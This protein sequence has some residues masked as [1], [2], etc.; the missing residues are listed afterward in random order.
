MK[1]KVLLILAFIISGSGLAQ[2]NSSA[3]SAV[4]V[5]VVKPLSMVKTADLSFGDIASGALDGTVVIA[6]D[7]TRQATRGVTLIEAGNTSNVGSFQI[8][9]FSNAS[10]TVDI[11]TSISIETQDGANQ[12]MVSNFMSNLGSNAVL[13]ERG[14]AT[15]VVG[16]TLNVPA[17]HTAGLYGGNFEIIVAYN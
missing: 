6:L 7:G 13:D 15:L 1:N 4:S 10:F 14:E 9:G 2:S 11:P 5:H 17:L 8:F 16:A 12:M 3:L